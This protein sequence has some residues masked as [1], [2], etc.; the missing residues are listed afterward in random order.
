ME[1]FSELEFQ[2]VRKSR[3]AETKQIYVDL[4]LTCQ[5]T[6]QNACF[7]LWLVSFL[8]IADLFAPFSAIVVALPRIAVPSGGLFWCVW[9]WFGYGCS[10]WKWKLLDKETGKLRTR[11]I[12]F[13]I[14]LPA[15]RLWTNWNSWPGHEIYRL[16]YSLFFALFVR[17]ETRNGEYWVSLIWIWRQRILQ[18][19][20]VFRSYKYKYRT[21]TYI[22]F[23]L[24][25]RLT[26]WFHI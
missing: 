23:D 19:M 9:F 20:C 6:Y 8:A 13:S 10:L 3:N 25:L 5:N 12:F 15:S 4:S 22:F 1:R 18:H 11:R 7:H 24:F 26:S 16:A 17:K 14:N 21:S 2:A